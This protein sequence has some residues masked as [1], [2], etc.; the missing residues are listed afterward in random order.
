MTETGEP[1]PPV[2]QEVVLYRSFKI[3]DRN[4]EPRK[5]IGTGRPKVLPLFD[6]AGERV[7]YT[8]AYVEQLNRE[9]WRGFADIPPE[10]R[11]PFENPEIVRQKMALDG[12]KHE[13]IPVTRSDP[14]KAGKAI[15]EFQHLRDACERCRR[16]RMAV[17]KKVYEA[18]GRDALREF[19]VRTTTSVESRS[20]KKEKKRLR[21]KAMRAQT[22]K[23]RQ[24]RHP[25]V[26]SGFREIMSNS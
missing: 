23:E 21:K 1:G 5:M 13:Y 24:K 6:S 16:D 11:A 12:K 3:E 25:V 7:L 14:A 2:V 4:V 22:K 8:R 26:N 19:Q 20:Q 15:T 10:N 9:G 18:G 17:M